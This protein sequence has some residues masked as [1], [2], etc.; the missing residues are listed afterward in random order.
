MYK[1][2]KA[3]SFLLDSFL[4]LMSEGRQLIGV[5]MHSVKGVP[6]SLAKAFF[7]VH[8]MFWSAGCDRSESPEKQRQRQRR[9]FFF[10]SEP[11]DL[12]HFSGSCLSAAD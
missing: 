12:R 4:S 2:S 8:A 9:K 5:L 10:D 11:N 1:P 6:K 3:H 7:A